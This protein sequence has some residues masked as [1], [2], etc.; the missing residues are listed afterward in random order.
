[1]AGSGRRGSSRGELIR[2][3]AQA[4]FVGRR[5]QLALFAENL[6]KDPAADDDPAEFLFHVRGLGGVGKSTLLRQWQETARRAGAVT[7]AV[8]ETDVH[9]VA[10]ALLELARQLAEQDGPLKD[11]D[12]AAEQYRREQ[13][14]AT[15]PLPADGPADAETSMSSRLVT[16]AALGA[17]SL[18]P[19]AGVVTA[20]TNPDAAAQGLDRLR[21]GARGRGR[22]GRTGDTAELCQSFVTELGRLC[23]RHKWVVLFLDTWELTGRYLGGWLRDLLADVFGPLP[24][25]VLVVLAGRD[26]LAE[27][28][29][30]L[31]R[32][33]VAEVPLEVFTEAE[34]RTLLAARGVT[35]PD[36]V[37]AVLQL[38]MGLPLLVQLLARTRPES[39][40]ELS[41]G[42]EVDRAVER[43]VQW[44]QDPRRRET[45]LACAL[46]PHLNEDVFA[47][48]VPEES[49]DLWEWLCRQPFVSGRGDF[50]QYHAVVRASIVRQ[51]RIRSPQSW[52][53]AHLRLAETHA[54]WR[55]EAERELPELK[56]WGDPAWR[57]LR[58]DE[59]YHLL[60]ARPARHLTTA[61]EDTV[62][63]TAQGAAV[64]RQW[65]DSL[66]QAARDS[67]DPALLAWAERLQLCFSADEPEIAHF[68]ALLAHGALG[69]LPRACAH[70]YRGW[71]LYR[72]GRD[73]EG[74]ADLERAVALAPDDARARADRGGG[75]LRAGRRDEAV[76]DFTA[77]LELDPDRASVLAQRA[78]AHRQS[79]RYD[80]AVADFTAALDRHHDRVY[81]LSSRG[82]AHRQAGRYDDAVTDL[83]AALDLRP[84]Y[85]WALAQR[86]EA[87]REAERY[88]EAVTDFTAALG[89][90]P[91]FAWAL[92][93]RGAAHRQ[94]GRHDEAIADQTA[95]LRLDSAYFWALAERGEVHREAG[96]YDEAVADL[97]AAL[98][99]SPRYAWAL[100]SRGQAHHGAGRYDEAVADLTAALELDATLDWARSHRVEA[101]YLAGRS[102]EALEDLSTVMEL[103]P[104]SPWPLAV[105]GFMHRMNGDYAQAAADYASALE[106][107]PDD[108]A[109]LW[110]VRD[111]GEFH[112]QTG[113]LAQ[114]VEDFTT[115]L[116]LNPDDVWSRKLRGISHRQ[117]GRSTEARED[118]TQ[119]LAASP[120]SPDVTF[121]KLM[122]DTVTSGPA[123]CLDQW[124]R[125]LTT[126]VTVQA[127]NAVRYF[128]LFRVLILEPHR[129]MTEAAEAFLAT[130][131]HHDAVVD[132]LRCLDEL[133]RLD[134][135]LALRA[136]A[137]RRV[138]A[139]RTRAG[140]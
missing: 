40:E 7:A 107:A 87:H 121:E 56:R 74:M 21:A 127:S 128:A 3:R 99:L 108:R 27:R 35:E 101:H 137:C 81:V 75:H 131:R 72:A 138:I 96:R 64:L 11:F 39:A 24:Q 134:H 105:R 33:Q 51:R 129:N 48:A 88:D 123:E 23:E 97:T 45:V 70:N 59:T 113:R 84:E 42:D 18:I 32:T 109:R 80:D 1:M 8:D 44:V 37:D 17:A 30:A 14:T 85:A 112:R 116:D 126:P 132:V 6:E 31:L 54:G 124:T 110:V 95:A 94:A 103:Q 122:L 5:A 49:R 71:Y 92:S 60:C 125:L 106:R 136:R 22:K 118:L 130:V 119:A 34:T 89:H 47:A 115:C 12:R 78:E 63:A 93:S 50:K 19:G 43:F 13:E 68:T 139:E 28:D 133:S 52:T 57:R 55:T 114:A 38:S 53:T 102:Q 67:A 62:Q 135:E 73:E 61:L 66:G 82:Q 29:W 90:D 4:Q 79:R 65:T 86:G 104:S 58:M 36:V 16:Q 20:M 117:A 69:T 120:G 25:N 41:D 111:R 46:V 100:G 9:G 98:A 140:D 2:Q 76:A 26:E 15:G 91:D 83:T 77:A 10:Q